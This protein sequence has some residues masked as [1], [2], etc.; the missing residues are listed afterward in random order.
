MGGANIYKEKKKIENY[1]HHSA[2][3]FAIA[4]CGL[5]AVRGK[6]IFLYVE[7]D[8]NLPLVIIVLASVFVFAPPQTHSHHPPG[9]I[10][11]AFFVR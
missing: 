1:I 10:L 7:G 3:T 6:L 9:Q 4:C 5:L 8:S 2:S 11:Q